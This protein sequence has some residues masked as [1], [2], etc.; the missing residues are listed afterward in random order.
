MKFE[1]ELTDNARQDYLRLNARWRAIVKKAFETHLRYEPRKESR[2]RI[3]RLREVE[4]PEYRLR[5]DDLRVFYQVEENSVQIL[6]IVL[7]ED[8][9]EWLQTF[10][11]R[12]T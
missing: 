11:K 9:E 8:A 5:I 6:A 10:G 7:K 4:W 2:S 12:K 3:K 1:I